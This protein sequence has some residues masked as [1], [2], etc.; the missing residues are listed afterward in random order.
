MLAHKAPINAQDNDGNTPLHLAHAIND[1]QYFK[2]FT[3]TK[4]ITKSVYG[5]RNDDLFIIAT[6]LIN[7]GADL[8][9][10]NKQGDTPLHTAV[11][12][13]DIPLTRLL[14]EKKTPI[15]T[16]NNIGE[17]ALSIAAGNNLQNTALYL[18]VI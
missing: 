13:T 8:T 4:S 9:I 1:P 17:T 15:D 14:I 2:Y 7:H 16:Q 12:N 6:A 5:N 3:K 10:I 18:Q 11:V